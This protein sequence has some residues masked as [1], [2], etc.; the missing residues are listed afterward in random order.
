MKKLAILTALLA[1]ACSDA[2]QSETPNLPI[3]IEGMDDMTEEKAEEII[4]SINPLENDLRGLEVAVRMHNGFRIKQDGVVFELGVIDGSGEVR[5]DE[6]FTLEE[7]FNVDSPTLQDAGREAFFVRTYKL[8]EADHDRMHAG[9][10]ILQEL[11]RTSP[12]ENQLKFNA[13]VFTCANPDTET[14]DEYRF[15]MFVRSASD[16]DFV[17]LS[18]GDVVMTRDNAGPLVVAW[19]PCVDQG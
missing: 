17:P 15:A 3:Q 1:V 6:A 10:L 12:G 7:T 16:V 13:G 5:I 9:D 18:N 8:S 14:P 2:S 4:G 19:E 11:K